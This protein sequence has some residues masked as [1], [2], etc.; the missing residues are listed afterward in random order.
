MAALVLAL[1]ARQGLFQPGP[2]HFVLRLADYAADRASEDGG[3]AQAHRFA[4]APVAEPVALI[5]VEVRD[6]GWN[7]IRDE[8]QPT[9]VFFQ[10]DLGELARRDVAIGPAQAKRFA[11]RV[12]FDD[13]SGAAHP[14]PFTVDCLHAVLGVVLLRPAVDHLLKR[15]VHA[16][17][18]LRMHELPQF[19]GLDLRHGLFAAD[20]LGPLPAKLHDPAAQVEFPQNE[21]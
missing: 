8:P 15:L 1:F 7:R 2:G 18:I 10:P 19:G 21:P 20:D 5:K 9:L 4:V 13:A 12:E 14:F 3:F 17:A 16:S 6:H 11:R